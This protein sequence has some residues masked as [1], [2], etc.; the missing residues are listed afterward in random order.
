ML[1][2]KAGLKFDLI[3]KILPCHVYTESRNQS[4]FFMPGLLAS[5]AG[6]L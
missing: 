6:V 5:I 4:G 3:F 2:K 1:L